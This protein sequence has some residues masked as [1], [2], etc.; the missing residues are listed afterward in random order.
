MLRNR[1][2]LWALLAYYVM[3]LTSFG[4]LMWCVTQGMGV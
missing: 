1:V 4:F 2:S 3:L